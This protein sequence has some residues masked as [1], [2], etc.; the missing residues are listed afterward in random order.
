MNGHY[1]VLKI[2]FSNFF[3]WWI[4]LWKTDLIK[5][6][7]GKWVAIYVKTNLQPVRKEVIIKSK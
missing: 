6:S 1:K 4:K 7:V 5:N 3:C 2:F